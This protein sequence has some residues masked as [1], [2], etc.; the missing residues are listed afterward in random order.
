MDL[1]RYRDLPDPTV[2]RELLGLPPLPTAGYTGHLYPGRGMTLLVGL[3]KYFP[4]INFL[5]VG[6][7]P[8][9][10]SEWCNRLSAEKIENIT[11]TGF[12]ENSQLPLYQAAADI[13]LMPYEKVISG[14]SGGDSST[15]ASPM[16]MFEYMA[17]KRAIIS[18]DLPV[19]QE[20]LNSSNAILCPPD[21]LD[22]WSQAIKSLI[23]DEGKRQ[24]L[25]QGAWQAI[26]QYTWLE[27]AR[28][29]LAEFP[30]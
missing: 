24:A 10:V 20:V 29:A 7:H 14:S 22:A 28:N 18:S 5:W 19:I 30:I 21:D 6:G 13:L 25:A 1:E 3:A 15:Y 12:V 9:D 2:A 16:K 8:S 4:H 11:L 27:R 26:Q 17:S 23:A